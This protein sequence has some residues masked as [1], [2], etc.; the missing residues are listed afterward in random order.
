MTT[1]GGATPAR[2]PLP[3]DMA[4]FDANSF[5]SGSQVVTMDV[6]IY[7]GGMNWTGVTHTPEFNCNAY[8]AM[9]GDITFVSGMTLTGSDGITMTKEGTQN[10]TTAGLTITFTFSSYSVTGTINQLD[11][12]NC[13]SGS[14]AYIQSNW[15]SNGHDITLSAGGM[16]ILND[17]LG[18]NLTV[19]LNN[20]YLTGGSTL[21]ISNGTTTINGNCEAYQVYVSGANVTI[22]GDVT[23]TAGNGGIDV[24]MGTLILNGGLNLGPSGLGASI[25]V[26]LNTPLDSIFTFQGR[27]IRANTATGDITISGGTNPWARNDFN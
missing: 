3:Q 4:I 8:P 17:Y 11:D 16:N 5:T 7:T 10:F 1:T 27:T 18:Q 6:F 24:N 2:V 12:I 25:I 14:G 13:S 20:V 26:S 15:N 9:Y 21:Q 22:H 19:T 23:C